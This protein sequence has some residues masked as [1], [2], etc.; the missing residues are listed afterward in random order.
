MEMSY[1]SDVLTKP[2]NYNLKKETG[3]LIRA[4]SRSNNDN[5]TPFL[6]TGREARDDLDDDSLDDQY[7]T[8]DAD[9]DDFS[10]GGK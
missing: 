9:I 2:T 5:E 4:L 1:Q 6:P 8:Q 7:A 3:M 10:R